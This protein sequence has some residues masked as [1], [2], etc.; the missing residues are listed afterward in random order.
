MSEPCDVIRI[1]NDFLDSKNLFSRT[2][3][4]ADLHIVVFFGGHLGFFRLSYIIYP[5]I[6]HLRK[7]YR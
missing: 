2:D 1:I 4:T 6:F 5:I 3:N 7:H